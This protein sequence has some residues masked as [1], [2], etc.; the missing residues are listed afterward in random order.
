[1]KKP[2][3]QGR[4]SIAHETHLLGANMSMTIVDLSTFHGYTDSLQPYL[5][6]V[7]NHGTEKVEDELCDVIEVSYMGGQRIWQLWLSQRDH[8]PRKLREVVHVSYDIIVEERWSEVKINDEIANELFV[9]KPP[10]DWTEWQLPPPAERL[11]KPGEAAPDF[12]LTLSDGKKM[13]LS[14]Q[15]GKVVWLV[16]WRVG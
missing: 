8:L 15:R 10:E 16:F 6:G 3:P 14:D 5:D 4:H 1:M 13:K 12:E 11:L 9:W 7:A 2:T